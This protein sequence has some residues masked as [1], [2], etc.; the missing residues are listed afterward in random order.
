[1]KILQINAVNSYGST[2]RTT[3]EMAEY[4][5]KNGY[6]SYVAYSVGT[7]YENGHKIGTNLE[8]K[9]HALGSRIIGKQGYFS[10]NGTKSLIRYIKEIKPD[11]VHLRNLHGNFINLNLLIEFLSNN[12]I[13][14]VITLHDC[15]FYTGKCTHYTV[16]GCFKWQSGCGNCPRLKKDNPSWFFDQ[17]NKM[18]RDKKKWFES[19]PRLAV[20]GVSDW[21]TNEAKKSFLATAH[22][23][24]RIYNWVDLGIFNPRD[25]KELRARYNLENKFIILGVASGWS[26]SKGLDKFIKLS[27]MLEKNEQIVL[28]GRIN[29]DIELPSNILV[30]SRTESTTEL[31]EYYSMADVFVNLSLQ[32][33]FGKVTAEALACGTPIIVLNSTANPELVGDGCG[34]VIDNSEIADLIKL[35]KVIKANGKASYTNSCITYAKI[36]F[37]KDDRILDYLKLYKKLISK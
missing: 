30:I 8:T 35:L 36:N 32:E 2:G 34:Y 22:T 1:M 20:V 27:G 31:A 13:A 10:W 33:S 3:F 15:W 14:T 24:T 11:I 19:I 9:F 6:G 21:I 5:K 37:S 16:D 26:N 17:T 4:L 12:D 29:P 7:P 28:V 18:Y 23:I 25:T